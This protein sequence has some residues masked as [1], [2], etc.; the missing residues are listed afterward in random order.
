MQ[1]LEDVLEHRR[2]K[3]TDVTFPQEE[4]PGPMKIYGPN[5]NGMEGPLIFMTLII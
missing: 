4:E 3:E 1:D 2:S 5:S